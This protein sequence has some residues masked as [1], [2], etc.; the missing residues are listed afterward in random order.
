MYTRRGKNVNEYNQVEMT[1]FS[2]SMQIRLISKANKYD[3]IIFSK[4]LNAINSNKFLVF[5]F[6]KYQ[7]VKELYGFL[8]IK[9]HKINI[10][11]SSKLKNVTIFEYFDRGIVISLAVYIIRII[12]LGERKKN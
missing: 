7:K 4:P 10:Y 12:R 11:A 3:F 9:N 6:T 2:R 5:F 8:E 1:L